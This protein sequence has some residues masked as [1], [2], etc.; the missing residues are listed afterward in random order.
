[1]GRR[2]DSKYELVWQMY[3]KGMSCIERFLRV[4]NGMGRNVLVSL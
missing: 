2:L 4:G 1:M 3:R